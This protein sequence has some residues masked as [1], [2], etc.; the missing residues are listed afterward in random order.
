MTEPGHDSFAIYIG[1]AFSTEWLFEDENGQAVDFTGYTGRAD[2][3]PTVAGT[4]LLRCDSQAVP[5]TL[6][7]PAPGVV[8]LSGDVAATTDLTVATNVFD[9]ALAPPNGQPE[10][11]L[12]GNVAVRDPVTQWD[13]P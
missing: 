8:R 7:F 1:L 2:I 13:A 5:P 3:R 10:I 6:T 12:M 11:W 4:L 9:L